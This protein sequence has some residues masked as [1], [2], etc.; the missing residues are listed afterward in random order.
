MVSLTFAVCLRNIDKG[1]FYAPHAAILQVEWH[2]RSLIKAD[3]SLSFTHE[4]QLYSGHSIC[5]KAVRC[6]P[7]AGLTA[8]T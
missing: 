3:V 2:G 8:R 6:K 7:W 5:E 1:E 4:A